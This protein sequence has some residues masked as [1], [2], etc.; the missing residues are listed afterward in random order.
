M[1]IITKIL[2]GFI[3]FLHLYFFWLESF[4]WTT[5]AKKV[6]KGYSEDFFHQ[7]KTLA[8]NQGVYNAFLAAGLI[9]SLFISDHHW[10]IYIAIF[11][12]VCVFIAGVY[13]VL[14]TSSKKILYIQAL[15]ALI[16]LILMHL[17]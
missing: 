17:I 5:K 16:A 13:G 2:I 15:P 9:W 1:H 8:A 3:A 4:V 7:T 14:T 11:F 10:K 6:F 12:L